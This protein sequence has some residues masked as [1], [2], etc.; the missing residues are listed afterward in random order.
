MYSGAIVLKERNKKSV[1]PISVTVAAKTRQNADGELT[2][3]IRFGGEDVARDQADL[4]Y[5]NGRMFG[6]ND[7]GWRPESGDWRFFYYDVPRRPAEGSL[8]LANTKWQDEAP[9]TDIDTLIFGRSENAYQLLDGSDPIGA[10]YILDTV[11]G[12]R[13]TNVGAGV[14]TFDT[15]TGG[16]EEWVTAPVQ[17][18][19]H[20]VVHHEVDW[21]GN[22]FYAPFETELGSATVNPNRV[23]VTTG[24]DSGEFDV[25]FRSTLD[26]PGLSAEG[27]G[28][29][30]PT[31]TTETARQDDPDDP[32]TSSVKVPVTLDHA[33]RA[34]FS[35]NLANNDIDLYVVYDAN[36]DGDFTLGEIVGASAT[37]TGD[38]SVELVNPPDGNYQVWVHGWAVAGSP[39]FPLTIFPVQGNDLQVTGVPSGPV[40]AGT[41]V[42][43]SVRFQREM[44]P[45]EDYFGELQLG[46]PAA[47]G[48]LSV[49]ITVHRQ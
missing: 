45:G 10:P 38:E 22:R 26:L 6:A 3:S 21:E 11:G 32:S 2:G 23:E 18:G 16:P 35:A 5:D 19:L 28:L 9:H 1:V 44:D 46:P 7:W 25:T 33:A 43:L 48:A 31:T 37:A 42:T 4:Q 34:T 12:S 36:N 41:P 30:Q 27:F 13:N 29:S 24:D 47:P 8:F 20:A 39:T 15:A 40:D 14:W 49:P 17:R